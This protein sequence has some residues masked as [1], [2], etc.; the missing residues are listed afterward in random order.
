[1]ATAL[2]LGRI[3]HYMMRSAEGALSSIT[4]EL[5]LL[6]AEGLRPAAISPG[7]GKSRVERDFH[8]QRVMG[9]YE[10]VFR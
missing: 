2:P 6:A 5:E 10:R 1:M 4:N 7:V 8:R 3:S 9:L